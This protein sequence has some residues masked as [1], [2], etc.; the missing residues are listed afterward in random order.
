MSR[1]LFI[2]GT[3]TGV[4][5]TLVGALLASAWHADGKRVRVLKPAETGCLPAGADGAAQ[6][7]LDLDLPAGA[8]APADAL[9]LAHYAHDPRAVGALCPFRYG[10][11]LAPAVAAAR[12][13]QRSRAAGEADEAPT[14]EEISACYMSAAEKA[15][16]VIVEGAGGVLVPY[17]PGFMGIDIAEA[18]VLPTLIVARLGL[19][20]I[21]HTLLTIGEARRR[22]LTIAGVVLSG[23][24]EGESIATR[25]NRETLAAHVGEL[26]LGVVPWLGPDGIA[27]KTPAE[28]AELAAEHIDL[29]RLQRRME[30]G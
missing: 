23:S 24:E 5:K 27:D 20:T 8:L 22:D 1:G 15:D 30:L 29:R 18:L 28:A 2:T 9:L 6:P 10:E 13:Q 4:G 19:G 25:T 12:A 16:L 11:P 21:N 26:L 3:D 14:I 17:A 7:D